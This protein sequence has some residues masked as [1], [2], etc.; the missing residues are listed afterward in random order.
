M[1]LL[2]YLSEAGIKQEIMSIW[3]AVSWLRHQLLV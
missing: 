2:F 3:A 1:T